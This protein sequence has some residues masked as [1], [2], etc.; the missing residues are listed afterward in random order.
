MSAAS[1]QANRDRKERRKSGVVLPKP[2]PAPRA[3][4]EVGSH[5]ASE[6]RA[7][8]MREIAAMKTQIRQHAD[9]GHDPNWAHKNG[10]NGSSD[11]RHVAGLRCAPAVAS[12]AHERD[13]IVVPTGTTKRDLRREYCRRVVALHP[14]RGGADQAFIDLTREYESALALAAK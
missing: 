3:D 9:K 7:H 5:L 4:R 2:Q 6:V 12:P 14:E 11:V 10:S 8:N 1:N 13:S